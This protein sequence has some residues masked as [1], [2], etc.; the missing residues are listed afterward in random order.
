M[1][2]PTTCPRCSQVTFWDNTAKK[3]TGEY[4]ANSPNFKC[5][6]KACG[7][8]IWPPKG[9]V[10]PGQENPAEV[11]T[12]SKPD[13]FPYGDNVKTNV[14]SKDF[15]NPSPPG[16]VEISPGYQ[17]IPKKNDGRISALAVVKS[18]IEVGFY[19]TEGKTH[20]EILEEVYNDVNIL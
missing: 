16:K 1:A 18:L 17:N 14:T 10:W 7:H 20:E 9:K 15:P 19:N 6:N 11:F 3:A 2:K 13:D 5:S 12:G 4:K 8:V